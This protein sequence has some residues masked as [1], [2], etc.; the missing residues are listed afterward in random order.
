MYLFYGVC[1][2]TIILLIDLC[3]ADNDDGGEDDGTGRNSSQK[4]D[5]LAALNIVA[6]AQN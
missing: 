5:A 1:L 6:D 2:A 4:A 3:A